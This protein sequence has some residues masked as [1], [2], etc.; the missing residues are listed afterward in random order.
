M[1]NCAAFAGFDLHN[2]LV[3]ILHGHLH[4][5]NI[6]LHLA[7]KFKNSEQQYQNNL[8]ISF[9]S[10]ELQHVRGYVHKGCYNNLIL[11]R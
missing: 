6:Y 10:L 9:E 4:A 11:N 2:S 1:N 7:N 3:H 5:Q 8:N